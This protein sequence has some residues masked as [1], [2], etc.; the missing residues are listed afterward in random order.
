MQIG[1]SCKCFTCQEKSLNVTYNQKHQDK[2]SARC[3]LNTTK[4]GKVPERWSIPVG[5]PEPGCDSRGVKGRNAPGPP[6]LLAQER[7]V[8]LRRSV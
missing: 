3:P 6:A 8:W 5:E 4:L 7:R 2:K 1:D